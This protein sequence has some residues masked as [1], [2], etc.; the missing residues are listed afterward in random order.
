M[1]S[2]LLEKYKKVSLKKKPPHPL[3]ACTDEI[4]KTVGY[5]KQYGRGYW[6]RLLSTY[7]KKHNL[8]A[9]VVFT[10]LLGVLKEIGGMDKKYPK[11][12]VLTNKLRK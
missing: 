2:N 11:G 12:A 3:S 8:E 1:D 7:R 10:F 5:T 6:L 9:E 4:Q